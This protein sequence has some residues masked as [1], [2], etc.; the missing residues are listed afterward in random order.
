MFQHTAA[1]RRLAS[2][3]PKSALIQR[4]N[5]QPP[6]GGWG[7]CFGACPRSCSFNTQ[8]PEGGWFCASILAQYLQVSTHSRPKAAA[9]LKIAAKSLGLVSTH[10]RPKA[11]GQN[12]GWRLPAAG[13]FNTQPPEGGWL[14]F[15]LFHRRFRVSFN[16]QPPEG[17]WTAALKARY[18]QEVSTHSRPKAA[19]VLLV[20]FNKPSLVS[21][22]SRP[23]AA[24][25]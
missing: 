17:G 7:L 21:T 3:L 10:S 18:A 1:R 6:E 15:R 5:T 11:A 19:V 20:Q 8:P 4:F 25:P 16:T 24:E 12:S 14:V 22:H 2:N 9:P 13:C 23:K